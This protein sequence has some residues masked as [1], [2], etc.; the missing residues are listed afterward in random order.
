MDDSILEGQRNFKIR[1]A[2]DAR[3]SAGMLLIASMPLINIDID[4]DLD[5]S[6][7]M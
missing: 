6:R 2:K 7:I 5:D 3:S 1:V 4:L